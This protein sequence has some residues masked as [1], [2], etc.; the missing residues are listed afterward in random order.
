MKYVKTYV[1]LGLVNKRPKKTAFGVRPFANESERLAHTS[2]FLV[3]TWLVVAG[4]LSTLGQPRQLLF[5]LYIH[6]YAANEFFVVVE[7][8]SLS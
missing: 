1:S 6:T 4:V 8:F 5:G 3:S 7:H 2:T